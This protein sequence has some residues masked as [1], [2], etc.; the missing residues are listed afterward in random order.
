MFVERQELRELVARKKEVVVVR[1][2]G[3]WLLADAGKCVGS[4][5]TY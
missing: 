2:G 3:C 1:L 5:L 4:C